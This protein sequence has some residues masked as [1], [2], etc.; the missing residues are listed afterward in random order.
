LGIVA[1]G[2][3][4]T[5]ACGASS[6]VG[7]ATCR[8][9]CDC[10]GDTCSCKSGGT[11]TFGPEPE[12]S[13][14][15]SDAGSTTGGGELPNDVSY[16][17]EARNTCDLTCGTGCNATCAG[18]SVCEGTCTDNCTS[19]CAGTSDCTL[20]TGTNSDVTCSGGSNCTLTLDTGSTVICQGNSSCT[21]RC[22]KGG[23]T[24]ECGGSSSCIV[25]CGGT[26]ACHVEC[27][28]T[29][30]QDCAAGTTCSGVCAR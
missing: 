18:R 30:A 5:T 6:E 27:N 1:L 15:G 25:E 29:R 16:D 20:Q 22:P 12:T 14:P 2:L 11:C 24:A 7:R 21:I 13:E 4:G 23:C 19:R 8:G 10:S 9:D 26:E 3:A 28:G 17:C